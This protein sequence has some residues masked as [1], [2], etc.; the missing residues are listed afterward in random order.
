LIRLILAEE[1]TDA[2]FDVCQAENGDE[3]VKLIENSAMAFTLL[4]T[5]IHMPGARDGVAV[6]RLMRRQNVRI[7]VIYTTGR[8]DIFNEGEIVA[9]NE[10]VL[11]KPFLPSELVRTA[12]RLLGGES[13]GDH[14]QRL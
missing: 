10:V 7:P 9:D 12:R 11:A 2:G 3:A 13:V 6:A 1:I 4:V 8:P 5:D 14:E